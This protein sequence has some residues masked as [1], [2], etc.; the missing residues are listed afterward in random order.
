MDGRHISHLVWRS[1]QQHVTLIQAIAWTT[2]WTTVWATFWTT[3]TCKGEAAAGPLCT[4]NNRLLKKT[5]ATDLVA[6][7]LLKTCYANT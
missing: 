1:L 4:S 7:Q 5:L 6:K 3:V 2:V